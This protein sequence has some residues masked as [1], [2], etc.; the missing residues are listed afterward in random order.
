MKPLELILTDFQGPL[1]LLLHLIKQ[2]QINIYDIPIA[3]ITEQYLNYLHQMKSLELDIAG[4]Y[5]VMASTLMRIKSQMLLPQDPIFEEDPVFVEEEVDPRSDLVAQLLT[6]QVYKL[7]AQKLK[8]SAQHRQCLLERPATQAPKEQPLQVKPGAYVVN[9]LALCLA[10]LLKKVQQQENLAQ[11]PQRE[12]LS[13]AQAQE[14]ILESLQQNS[15]MTFLHLL[16]R[17]AQVE[18]VV[19]KFMAI[20]ELIKDG[21][22]WA[23]QRELQQDILMK[24]R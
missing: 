1:D 14:Q 24:L 8:E 2:A 15:E 9:D 5:L 18:E 11:L 23:Q 12:I 16:Q 17:S 21:V 19:T 3:Q 13:V 7:A 20:L 10:D 6:Y 4:E 22:I